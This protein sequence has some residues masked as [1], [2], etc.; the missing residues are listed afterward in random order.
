M[1][2]KT[3]QK[4]TKLERQRKMTAIS[5]GSQLKRNP[6]LSVTWL[7][8]IANF[9]VSRKPRWWGSNTFIIRP[10]NIGTRV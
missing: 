6:F 2:E 4:H 5:E 10:K 7:F 3:K 9:V 8:L 1:K